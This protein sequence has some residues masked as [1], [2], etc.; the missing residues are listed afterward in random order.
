AQGEVVATVEKQGLTAP[1]ATFFARGRAGTRTVAPMLGR[2]CSTML[3]REVEDHDEICSELRRQRPDLILWP[4]LMAPA[5]GKE[6]QD[7]P[8]HVQQAGRLARSLGAWIVQSNWPEQLNY[9]ERS[10]LCGR[11]VVLDPSGRIALALPSNEAGLAVFALGENTFDW[12][13]TRLVDQR[14]A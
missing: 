10:W 7:P 5:D 1:E 2:R 12:H 3:C 8:E 14:A 9:P 4:G 6:L 11:S 13:P